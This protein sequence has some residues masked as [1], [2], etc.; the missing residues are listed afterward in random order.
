MFLGAR[1][2]NGPRPDDGKFVCNMFPCGAVELLSSSSVSSIPSHQRCPPN[3]VP[4]PASKTRQA[5]SLH[6][7]HEGRGSAQA[8]NQRSRP[9]REVPLAL[10]SPR[11][12]AAS[13][14]KPLTR[15]FILADFRIELYTPGAKRDINFG[16]VAAGRGRAI[17]LTSVAPGSQA[18]EVRQGPGPSARAKRHP[19]PLCHDHPVLCTAYPAD[20][21][22]PSA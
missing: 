17:V 6:H 4:K 10:S 9:V 13:N 19:T 22:L 1:V 20:G 12:V 14:R 8:G 7:G 16:A 18:E 21:T 11:S 2:A 3:F 15:R 5:V